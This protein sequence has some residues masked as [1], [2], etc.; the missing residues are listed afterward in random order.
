MH[1]IRSVF[2][3]PLRLAL[4]IG[5]FIAFLTVAATPFVRV[6]Q[7]ACEVYAPNLMTECNCDIPDPNNKANCL[8]DYYNSNNVIMYDPNTPICE[9]SPATVTGTG[10]GDLTGNDNAEKIFR[11][12]IGKGLTAEQAAGVMG[13][14]Y[15]ESRLDPAIEQGGRIVD[16][17]Y[18]LIPNVGF[19][20]AQ[21]T[22]PGRQQALMTFQ[23]NSGKTIIDLSMQMDFLWQ[24]LSGGGGLGAL[25]ATTT[26][27]DAAYIFHAV[28]ERSADSEATVRANRGGKAREFYEQFKSIAPSAPASANPTSISTNCA[29][30][31]GTGTNSGS[32]DLLS[33]SFVIYNQCQ[34]PPFGGPWGTIPTLGGR[35]ACSDACIPTSLAMISKNLAGMNVTPE[36]TIDYWSQHFLWYGGGGSLRSSPLGA[37]GD[38]GLRIET[39]ANKGDINAYKAVFDQGGAVMALAA[40]SSPFLPQGHAIVLR[41][42]VNGGASFLIADPGYTNTNYP[43]ANQPSVDKILTDMRSDGASV[44]YAFY[45][46]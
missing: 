11:F 9:A 41:G 42:I 13:N 46:K 10:S 21:W 30:T 31:P 29:V 17:S 23:R 7:A 40:G 33:D 2:S 37:A 22:D 4:A 35:T 25:Q 34:Y 36:N 32:A 5:F 39:I 38:F 1:Y 16:A 45:K 19:G 12:L 24:E 15:A 14:L 8:D 43:P 28:F 20:L 3:H 6:A 26:P 27:E 18:T 44:A